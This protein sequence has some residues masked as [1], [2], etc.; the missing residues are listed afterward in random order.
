MAELYVCKRRCIKPNVVHWIYT[1]LVE[2][3]F[4]TKLGRV[5]RS[6]PMHIT[7]SLQST[8]SKALKTL[9]NFLPVAICGKFVANYKAIRLNGTRTVFRTSSERAGP[10]HPQSDFTISFSQESQE[11]T[12]RKTQ[13]AGNKFSRILSNKMSLKTPNGCSNRRSG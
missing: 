6:A 7:S 9:P 12:N 1:F 3:T 10:H 5:W 4:S 2:A 13:R 8:L 11:R